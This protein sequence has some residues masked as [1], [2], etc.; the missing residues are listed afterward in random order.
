MKRMRTLSRREREIMDIVYRSESVTG[1]EVHEQIPDPPS[2]SAVRA[3][4]RILEGK[5]LLRHEFDGKRYVYRPTLARDKARKGA[6]EHLLSTFFEGSAAGAVMALLEQ[7][8]LEL[9]P[10]DLDRMAQLI[11]TARKEGR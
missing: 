2:Y 3:T 5:G 8:G 10:T 6:I 1:N 7:R 11:Q 4:L 9:T